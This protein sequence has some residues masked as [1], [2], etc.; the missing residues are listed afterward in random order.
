M[1]SRTNGNAE[2]EVVKQRQKYGQMK[3][4]KD[5]KRWILEYVSAVLRGLKCLAVCQT[6]MTMQ[7]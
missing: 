3:G 7:L 4:A 1:S 2:K 6:E 5:K